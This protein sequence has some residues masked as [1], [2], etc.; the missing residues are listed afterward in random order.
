MWCLVNSSTVSVHSRPGDEFPCSDEP[1]RVLDGAH[2]AFCN[3][4]GAALTRSEEES[5]VARSATR[6]PESEVS[7]TSARHSPG[8]VVDHGE[9]TEAA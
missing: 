5:S 7:A 1:L 6:V 3:R 2:G 9:D 4:G 8:A